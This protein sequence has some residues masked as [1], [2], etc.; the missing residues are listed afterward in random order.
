[1]AATATVSLLFVLLVY[2]MWLYRD[3]LVAASSL[4]S[5]HLTQITINLLPKAQSLL[6]RARRYRKV[7]LMDM[8]QR[9]LGAEEIHKA[10]DSR[11]IREALGG[12]AELAG[13]E[14]PTGNH[15]DRLIVYAMAEKEAFSFDELVARLQDA[16]A[17]W[18]PQHLHN[19]LERLELA[20]ILERQATTYTFRVPLFR[21]MILEQNPQ[22][23]LAQE[24]RR[25][26]ERVNG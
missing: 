10:L 6:R 2:G 18:D 17:T 3:P 15:H 26:K 9:Q 22:E 19:A 4:D 23:M 14:D 20:T 7:L 8:A 13:K 24:I 5:V 1:M 25:N 12:W 11:A 21:A 16:H